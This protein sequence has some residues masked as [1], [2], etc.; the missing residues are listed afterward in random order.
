M[1]YAGLTLYD[2]RFGGRVTFDVTAA[3]SDGELMSTTSV[4]SAGFPRPPP[5]VHP[6]QTERF[7]V[8]RGRLRVTHGWRVHLL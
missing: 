2:A 4:F 3:D 5:H 7:A 6:H 8:R 1:V